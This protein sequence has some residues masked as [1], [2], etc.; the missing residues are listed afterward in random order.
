MLE[1]EQIDQNCAINCGVPGNA[2]SKNTTKS[3][4]LSESDIESTYFEIHPLVCKIKNL[5]SHFYRTAL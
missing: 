4:N 1:A 5:R 3:R 2:N